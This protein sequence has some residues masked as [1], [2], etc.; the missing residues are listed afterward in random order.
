[1]IIAEP[2]YLTLVNT[3][4]PSLLPFVTYI[5]LSCP[6]LSV[7]HQL[8]Q[9][10]PRQTIPVRSVPRPPDTLHTRPCCEAPD[11][12]IAHQ[13]ASYERRVYQAG[14]SIYCLFF[15]F[16]NKFSYVSVNNH[17]LTNIH[18]IIYPLCLLLIRLV[19]TT[20]CQTSQSSLS[21]GLYR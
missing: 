1:V 20:Y 7:V 3:Y 14:I 16:V 12:P 21:A 8:D 6:C 18:S 2:V 11:H 5:L 17:S 9:Y 4:V 10:P 13:P 19:T 15:F